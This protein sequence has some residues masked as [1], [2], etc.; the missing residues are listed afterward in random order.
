MNKTFYAVGKYNY[1]TNEVNV[2]SLKF[3]KSMEEAERFYLEKIYNTGL[4]AVR[5]NPTLA[6]FTIVDN[7]IVSVDYLYYS[8]N[9]T[10][11]GPIGPILSKLQIEVDELY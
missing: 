2:E 9:I 5:H 7:Y 10:H 11:F 4:D 3:F 8:N 1:K 6:I